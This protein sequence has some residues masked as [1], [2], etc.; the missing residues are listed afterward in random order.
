MLDAVHVVQRGTDLTFQMAFKDEAGAA[1]DLTGAS[2]SVE[3]NGPLTATATITN[4][5]AGLGQLVAPYDVDWLD[6]R[7]MWFR[8]IL[9]QSGG[10]SIGYPKTWL[11][12]R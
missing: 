8:V 6:G 9:T 10:Q 2:L 11:D 3:V 7:Q 1:I 5:A 4:A 12:V